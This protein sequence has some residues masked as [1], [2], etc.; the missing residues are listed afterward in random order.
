[1][2]GT[3]KYPADTGITAH[4]SSRMDGSD[5]ASE[6]ENHTALCG[7]DE[8]QHSHHHHYHHAHALTNQIHNLEK[9]LQNH[10]LNNTISNVDYGATETIL[11]SG[12]TSLRGARKPGNA[13]TNDKSGGHNHNDRS[14]DLEV[15]VQLQAQKHEEEEQPEVQ[16]D[17]GYAWVVLA[18]GT[19]INAFSWG[20]SGSFGVFLATFLDT[21]KYPG[22]T[23]I[24]FAFVGGL[25]FGV[26]LMV[27]PLVIQVIQKAPYRLVII[28]GAFVQAGAYIAASFATQI[29]HLYLSQ[30]L[31]NGIGIGMVF[32]PANATLP[33]WFV[34]RRGMANGIFTSGAG[35][36]SILFSLSV[37]TLIDRVS[38]PWAQRYVGL[39]TCGF[40]LL[41]GIFIKERKGVYKR[42]IKPY[43]SSLLHRPDLWI[44]TFWGVITLI[45]YGIVLYT[46][47]PYAVSVGLTHHQG[48]VLSAVVSTGLV[49]GRPIM[50]YVG[51]IIGSVNVS[52]VTTLL[53]ATFIL[54]WWIPSKSYGSLIALSFFL[55]GVCSSFSVGFPPICASLVELEELS[56]ML[57][58]SWTVI[59]ALG[60]FST[61]IA[62]GLTTVNG[63]YLY[64]QI[65]TGLL[66]FVAAV[67]LVFIRGIQF[68][69][70][71]K[72]EIMKMVTDETLCSST[73]TE[74]ERFKQDSHCR[75]SFL[76]LMFK[77][78][79][80]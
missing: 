27:S 41:S 30:G 4:C 66:F 72:E 63:S 7:E 57:S 23:R 17:C 60:I 25:Q 70:K 40:C 45:C 36:G 78:A 64:S 79:K 5:S 1:M 42:K 34:K 29:W 31:L 14:Q 56:A 50:G 46:M 68:R 67:M 9:A 62:I 6:A 38:L 32:V 55:G 73:N 33:L 49:V 61:P 47:A 69:I 76:S 12:G 18:A 52:L 77:I 74:S 19:L 20:A 16:F 11:M 13:I 37:Q 3:E 39:M 59:G 26:G 51:D 24:N 35:M 65:F 80:I 44:A 22:A 8:T 48:S 53:S 15:Q 28:L 10:D 75:K 43:E 54:A 58:M 71:E 21:N 2:N